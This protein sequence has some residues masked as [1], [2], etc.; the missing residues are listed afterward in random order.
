MREGFIPGDSAGWT[1]PPLSD[2]GGGYFFRVFRRGAP[3]NAYYG[4]AQIYPDI[5]DPAKKVYPP[6]SPLK[7][8]YPLNQPRKNIP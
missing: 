3:R 1:F 8:V 7:K 6:K 5:D 4:S 2:L